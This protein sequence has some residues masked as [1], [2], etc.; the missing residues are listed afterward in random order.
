MSAGSEEMMHAGTVRALI[1]RKL[2]RNIGSAPLTAG[3]DE[4]QR[5]MAYMAREELAARWVAT[6]SEDRA[7][8]ARRIYYLSMEFL[9]GRALNN[10]LDA[11][12]LRDPAAKA[13]AGNGNG[14]DIDTVLATEPD[15]ALGNGGLGR[16]AAD[17]DAGPA[18]LG[19]RHA[20]RVRHVRAVDRQRLPDRAS[21]LLAGE[22]YALG[23]PAA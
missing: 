10:A 21:G 4:T 14:N 11:L 7:V 8:K 17:G 3:A 12:E 22:R 15:A 2:L 9:V 1:D 19:L 18:F 6:Q 16:L 13:L 5:A 23:V 20:L